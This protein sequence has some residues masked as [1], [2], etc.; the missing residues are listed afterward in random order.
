MTLSP[1]HSARLAAEINDCA[2]PEAV[3]AILEAKAIAPDQSQSSDG[4]LTKWLDPTVNILNALSATLGQGIGMV[5]CDYSNY[6]LYSSNTNFQ[7][8]PPITI[9][10]SGIDI[11]VVSVRADTSLDTSAFRHFGKPRY[12]SRTLRGDRKLP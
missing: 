1:T 3:L 10:F 9:I 7:V 6:L 11:L 8:F 5:S 2:S 12:A 4:R